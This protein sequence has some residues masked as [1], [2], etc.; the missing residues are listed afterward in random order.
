VELTP[1]FP[2]LKYCYPLLLF[3]FSSPSRSP[4]LRALRTLPSLPAIF[5][6]RAP[7]RGSF[8]TVSSPMKKN[9]GHARTLTLIFHW[10]ILARMYEFCKPIPGNSHASQLIPFLEGRMIDGNFRGKYKS[11]LFEKQSTLLK[12]LYNVLLRMHTRGPDCGDALVAEMFYPPPLPPCTIHKLDA[13]SSDEA[14]SRRILY[15]AE[16]PD[17]DAKPG[18]HHMITVSMIDLTRGEAKIVDEFTSRSPAVIKSQLEKLA[19][20][21]SKR[22]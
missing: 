3:A 20:S 22:G 8:S 18:Y 19:N 5:E 14:E 9:K 15:E 7:N 17:S 11:G 1:P 12:D 10:N 13:W 6:E 21:A 2:V 4:I 16:F